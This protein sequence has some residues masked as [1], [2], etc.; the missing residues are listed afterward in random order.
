MPGLSNMEA[1]ES[2]WK[3]TFT[4]CLNS[5]DNHGLHICEWMAGIRYSSPRLDFSGVAVWLT[6]RCDRGRGDNCS[7][8]ENGAKD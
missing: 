1:Q 8:S 5:V 6:P 3:L 2:L 7:A 4:A